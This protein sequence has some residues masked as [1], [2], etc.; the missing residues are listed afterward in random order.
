MFI[1][2]SPYKELPKFKPFL[3]PKLAT[4]WARFAITDHR[5]I[6]ELTRPEGPSSTMQDFRPAQKIERIHK[7]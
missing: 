2:E 1:S 3:V 7:P 6:L 4:H 5:S